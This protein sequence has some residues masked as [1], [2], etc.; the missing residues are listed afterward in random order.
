MFGP[1]GLTARRTSFIRR[2]LTRELADALP[3]G[4]SI[5]AQAL[6]TLT[7][8]LLAHPDAIPLEQPAPNGERQWTTADLLATERSAL[9]HADRLLP[10]R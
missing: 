5:S 4:A 3:G 10:P 1:R 7:E 8:R 9:A 6:E 2:D